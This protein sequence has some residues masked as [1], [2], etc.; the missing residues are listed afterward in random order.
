MED[1]NKELENLNK[2]FNDKIDSNSHGFSLTKMFKKNGLANKITKSLLLFS[3]SVG[4]FGNIANAHTENLLNQDSKIEQTMRFDKSEGLTD[5]KNLETLT[6][7][8]LEEAAE[9]EMSGIWKM[10]ET[11][12]VVILTSNGKF[13]G[14]S[15]E[16]A[17]KV[18]DFLL[19]HQI[20]THE[21]NLAP[22]AGR[23][24][25]SDVKVINLN[26]N[27]FK[28]NNL[29]N[30]NDHSLYLEHEVALTAHH[31]HNHI[32]KG[33]LEKIELMRE[34]KGTNFTGKIMEELSS[35][36]YSFL[37]VVKKANLDYETSIELLDQMID[38]RE[39]G[40]SNHLDL[41]H[42]T[43]F[44][45]NS[46]KSI[47]KN[48]N[49]LFNTLKASS[50][51][52]ID[53]FTSDFA[54]ESF[55]L[56][57]G[58]NVNITRSDMKEDLISYRSNGN[59]LN[60]SE[61]VVYQKMSEMKSI[62]GSELLDNFGYEK[63]MED[64]SNKLDNKEG[65][66][67]EKAVNS[68]RTAKRTAR[69]LTQIKSIDSF[70]SNQGINKDLENVVYNKIERPNHLEIENSERLLMSELS[71]KINNNNEVSQQQKESKINNKLK[72]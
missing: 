24:Y 56:L 43:H 11:G 18:H 52:E 28:E 41:A 4:A 19:D 72:I 49:N 5:Y 38:I 3:L 12:D 48:D 42:S 46:L 20:N 70:S 15:P 32:S 29:L 64:M 26:K 54:Y 65:M 10:P 53:S 62:N 67:P 23:L 37:M 60:K 31:E 47:I 1:I 17:Q 50:S 61:S 39:Q 2:N 58:Q 22:E 25:G 45:L 16:E 21:E 66:T 14:N 69:A 13:E 36:S 27:F 30:D 59:V 71:S 57:D 44:G 9:L 68:V 55:K 51:S 33:Q 35:D 6:P 34:E 8:V 7:T 40:F 63:L